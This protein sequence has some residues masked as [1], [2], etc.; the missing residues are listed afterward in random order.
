VVLDLEDTLVHFMALK[1]KI[2]FYLPE[3]LVVEE[4]ELVQ[5]ALEETELMDVEEEAEVLV[6][7]HVGALAEMVEMD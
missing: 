4:T 5:E 2:Y 7:L 1:N 3:D 6:Q